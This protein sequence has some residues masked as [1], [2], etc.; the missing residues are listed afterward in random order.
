MPERRAALTWVGVTGLGLVVLA[1]LVVPWDWTPGSPM[2]PVDPTAGLPAG[3]LA[4]ISAYSDRATALGLGATAVSLLVAL[5]LGLTSWGS[6]L[7]DRLPGARWWPLRVLVAVLALALVSRV[8]TLPFA[9]PAERLRRRYGLSTQ[10]WGSYTLDRLR[11]LLVAVVVTTLVMGVVVALARGGRRAWWLLASLLAGGL[12][13]VGS[14]VY[15]VVIEPLY[16]TFTPMHAGP[17]RSSLI[18]L[19]EE[20][21]IRV[22][23]VLVADASRRTTAVNAYVSGFG[24]TKR[25]V[26]YDTLLDSTPDAQVRQVV[27]HELGHATSHDVVTGTALGALGAMAGVP[28]LVLVASSGPVRRRAGID[29]LRSARAVPLLLALFAVGS[30]LVL[31]AQNLVSRAIEARA[32]RHALELTDDPDTLVTLQQ[33]LAETNLGDP[34]PPRWRYLLFASHPTAAQRVAL[35]EA[36]PGDG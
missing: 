22:D 31:P 24:A 18:E 36:W 21:G 33:R 26:V 23:D 12:V 16:N 7:V 20:D 9:I 3:T 32:D 35:A 5:L 19:A 10:D 14:F 30:L 25:I 2:P 6:R 4:R 13:V 17:L 27:A 15:P 11:D 8:V 34:D 29:D 28:L 1:A